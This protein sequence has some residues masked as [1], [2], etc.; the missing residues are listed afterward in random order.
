MESS[1]LGER[2]KKSRDSRKVTQDQL[3][4]DLHFSKRTLIEYEKNTSEPAVSRA[5]EIANYLKVDPIW[6]VFGDDTSI[7]VFRED[8]PVYSSVDIEII[9]LEKEV[10]TLRKVLSKI[11][12]MTAIELKS[13]ENPGDPVELT[14]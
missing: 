3:A 5:I 7:T 12:L 10:E 4:R 8:I 13:L 6:L 2:I 14:T 9:R 11:N 1:K